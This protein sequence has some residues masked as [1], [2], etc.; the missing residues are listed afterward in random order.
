MSWLKQ[1]KSSTAVEYGNEE[2][3]RY[4]SPPR[5]GTIVP[6]DD[7][8]RAWQILEP[9]QPFS[10]VPMVIKRP[11]SPKESTR[12]ACISDTHGKHRQVYIPRCDVLLHGG[13][14]TQTGEH[15]I[16]QDIS[17]YFDQLL[18]GEQ[19][20]TS[21]DKSKTTSTTK[22]RNGSVGEIICIA[23]NH[24]LTLQPETYA[25]N[26]KTFHPMNGPLD[27]KISKSL[28]NHCT[29]LQDE[30][31]V[32][33]GI[34]LYGS[35]WSPVFGYNWAFNSPRKELYKKWDKIPHDTDVLITHGPPIGRGDL[36][37]SDSRAGCVEL[38][39]QVQSRIR[40]RIH[41]FGHIHEAY[42]VTSDGQTL[43]VNASSVTL[44]YRAEQA[45]IVFDLP[46]DK[47]LP[48]VLVLPQCTLSGDKV[49]DL[50]TSL[51]QH[52]VE[53]RDLIPFFKNA[54]PLL[55]GKD[56]VLSDIPHVDYEFINDLM[57]RLQMHRESN[58]QVLRSALK[59]FVMQ[60]RTMS[61]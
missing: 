52:E 10:K 7:P 45:C 36:C 16:I 9:K 33:S 25:K 37:I 60:V 40:P 56:L 22:S 50:L 23:G 5:Q 46:H 11:Y 39:R 15:R 41:L 28:L 35:P 12:I 24:D 13:D 8:D 44:T 32:T 29:Y 49:L 14:F 21:P 18:R 61:Y 58:L 53:Y 19:T 42:G 26:W 4:S 30:S 17:T 2:E 34:K 55:E 57:C 59:N 3:Q 27:T 38:L 54:T 1:F 31:Y 20:T 43:Y 51:S 47:T 48:A 6:M